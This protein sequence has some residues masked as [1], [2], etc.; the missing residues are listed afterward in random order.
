MAK[1]ISKISIPIILVGIFAIVVF[2]AIDSKQM[3]FGFYMVLLFFAIYVFSFGFATGQN[4]VSPLRKI[5]DEATELSNGNLSSRVYL[6]T[7]DE[8]SDLAKIFNKIAEELEASRQQETNMEKSVGIKVKAKTQELEETINALDQKVKNRTI[9]LERLIK[10]SSLL[11]ADVKNKAEETA[12]LKKE[13]SDFKQKISKYG[14]PKQQVVE[15][16]I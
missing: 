15:N 3:S 7:K 10:E 9:E 14:K 8:L 5:I 16:N 4:L 6:E 1:L 11:Q 2:L 13:L 12:R